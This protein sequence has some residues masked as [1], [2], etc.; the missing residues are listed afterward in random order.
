MILS[1]ATMSLFR[2]NGLFAVFSEKIYS[3]PNLKILTPDYLFIV[4][5]GSVVLI[6][7]LIAIGIKLSTRFRFFNPMNPRNATN[8][9]PLEPSNPPTLRPFLPYM[10]IT[11]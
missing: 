3:T 7:L 10:G 9:I 8:A 2:V 1:N 11:L 4:F 6:V 5:I